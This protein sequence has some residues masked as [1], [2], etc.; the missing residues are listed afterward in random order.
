MPW[1][2]APP[3]ESVFRRREM[4]G[5]PVNER[6]L[7]RKVDSGDFVRIAPGSFAPSEA[8]TAVAPIARHAQRVWEAATRLQPGSVYSHFAASAIW[9]IE[10]L[11]EWPD[12]VDVSVARAKGGR[13]TGGIRRHT[14]AVE[15][16]EVVP[17]GAHF[18]TTPV[19][20]ALDLAAE[21][22]FLRGV[23]A[24]DQ[25]LWTRRPGGALATSEQMLAGAASYRGRGAAR[26]QRVA[27]FARSGADSVRETQSRV[28]IARMG[29]PQPE[30]QHRFT[31]PSGR[32]VY[33][34]FWWPDEKHVGE[35]DGIGKYLDP[36]LLRG[37][38][39]RQAL[40][41]EKDREDELR[42]VVRALARWRTPA[43]DKPALLYDILTA[44]GLRSRLA[45]P[46]R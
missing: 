35:F 11:G 41:E 5:D 24:A 23:V 12:A 42:R 7:R 2:N 10:T 30:L 16:I 4:F 17:W 40:M 8:W 28:L 18:V 21:Q 6:R 43:L 38:S 22:T 39:P 29:F 3:I 15:L 25:A 33:S 46:A 31:L 44:T 26:V 20:T 13:S 9:G 14:R 34:D 37:R 1:L 45:R 36:E 27:E 32:V 19:Q